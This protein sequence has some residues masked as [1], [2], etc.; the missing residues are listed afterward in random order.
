MSGRRLPSGRESLAGLVVLLVNVVIMSVE[1]LATRLLFPRFGNT[2]FTWSA[3]IT[4]VIAGLFAGYWAGGVLAD[5]RQDRFGLLSAELAAASVLVLL[6][7]WLC[8]WLLLSPSLGDALYPPLLGCFIVFGLPAACLACVP[9]AA[10]GVSA[11]EGR[12]AAAASGIVS[13][14]SALGSVAGTLLT[15]FWL[16]PRFGVR[17]LFIGY[18]AGL[19]A[20]AVLSRVYAAKRARAG[21]AALAAGAF[22]LGLWAARSAVAHPALTTLVEPVYRKESQYQLVRVFEHGSGSQLVRLLMLD[23][24]EEGAMKVQSQDVV[25]SYT[26][27]YKAFVNAFK[28]SEA[29]RILYIGGGAYTMPVRTAELLPKAEVDVA[30]LDPAVEAAA[31]KYFRAGEPPNLRTILADGRQ[32][33]A[34]RPGT[35]DAIFVDAYQGVYAIPFHLAT[36]EF[37]ETLK[38]ALKP[39]GFVAFNVIGSVSEQKGFLC[40]FAVTL[41]QVFPQVEL[42]PVDGIREYS[43]NVILVA[44]DKQGALS[45]DLMKGAKFPVRVDEEGLACSKDALVLT[46]DHAP[47]EWLVGQYLAKER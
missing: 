35:Y 9:P 33:A 14:L 5:R 44:G 40:S 43:Q 16:I 19:F 11:A 20:L 34:E 22:G 25:F 8:D 2:I 12:S 10:V 23:S 41:R 32:A 26:R 3:V 46:D 6:V 29:R 37:F 24:T 17:S 38:R 36:R 13:A 28:P 39:G 31:K 42:Y 15:T 4:I 30:E 1:L 7:P 21:K 47:V 18:G 45:K 27:A